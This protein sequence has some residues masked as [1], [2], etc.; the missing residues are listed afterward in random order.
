MYSTTRHPA[1][2]ERR[3]AAVVEVA[4]ILPL[5]LAGVFTILSQ[6]LFR[7]FIDRTNK[8]V[9]LAAGLTTG[10]I[11][12]SIMIPITLATEETSSAKRTD[13]RKP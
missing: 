3:G 7:Y 9:R 4:L 6:P 11:M 10:T 2:S 5:F 12:A 1:K 8:R 13:R